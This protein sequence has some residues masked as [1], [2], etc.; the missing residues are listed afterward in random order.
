MMITLK[1]AFFG[2]RSVTKVAALFASHTGAESAARSLLDGS[3]LTASQ[4]NILS[5][6]DGEASNEDVLVRAVEPEQRGIGQTLVRTHVT[7]GVLGL[8]VGL[9]LY[10]AL[11][12]MG[13]PGLRS[14]PV[15]GLVALVGFG[16]TFGLMLGG[17][18][19]LRPDQGRVIGLVRRGLQSGKWAVVAH[20]LDATQTHLVLTSLKTG[21]M[22]IMRSF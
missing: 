14:T 11:T 4:V 16:I 15:V 17:V 9:L 12:A 7:M 5:P 6:S 13:S 8:L 20:P 22:R 10:A 2:E 1:Q 18:V 19:S 3:G 21:S